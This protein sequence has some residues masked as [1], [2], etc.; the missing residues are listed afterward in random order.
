MQQEQCYCRIYPLH[1]WQP[2]QGKSRPAFHMYL[3]QHPLTAVAQ[4]HQ[5][6]FRDTQGVWG[7][8]VHEHENQPRQLPKFHRR[9]FVCLVG[10]FWGAFPCL[11]LS[12]GRA[13]R[14]VFHA[15]HP[16]VHTH[17]KA[18]FSFH[19]QT[20]GNADYT[21]SASLPSRQ[22]PVWLIFGEWKATQTG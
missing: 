8:I 16:L 18:Q 20:W 9:R 10:L 13:K 22:S 21:P 17:T 1:R 4:T 7:A 6:A 2:P 3:Q 12:P 14:Q 15:L 19:V 11:I 5:Y